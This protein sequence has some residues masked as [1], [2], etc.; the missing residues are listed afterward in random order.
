MEVESFNDE[1]K[2]QMDMFNNPGA[3]SDLEQQLAKVGNEVIRRF[4]DGSACGELHIPGENG[5][6]P[7][8]RRTGFVVSAQNQY[9]MSYKGLKYVGRE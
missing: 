2:R 9:R 3:P 5:C 4:Q 8:V 6:A 1:L 7:E